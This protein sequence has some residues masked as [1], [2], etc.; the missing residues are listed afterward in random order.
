MRKTIL[1][2]IVVVL[3]VGVGV[4]FSVKNKGAFEKSRLLCDKAIAFM[5]EGDFNSA[6]N[7]LEQSLE[8]NERYPK[9]HYALAVSYLRIN[10]PDFSSAISHRDQAQKL[11][12]LV[13]EWFDN[14]LRILRAKE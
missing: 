8:F 7:Y 4:I 1:F 12:Y 6:I 13:P 14:Y 11:G 5:E 9:A 10:P 2:A 3:V